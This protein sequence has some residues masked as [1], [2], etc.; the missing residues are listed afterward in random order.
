[1]PDRVR[2]AAF[3]VALAPAGALTGCSAP[4]R[5]TVR[6][7]A[8]EPTSCAAAVAAAFPNGPGTLAAYRDVERRCASLEE[9]ARRKAF[10]G[11]ILRLDCAPPD[12]LAMAAEI[13][14]LGRKIPAAPPELIVMPICRQFNA[15][16]ADYD[17]L[18]RDHATLARKPTMANLGLFVHHRALYDGCVRKYG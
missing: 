5:P 17:E 18:R 3:L 1:M 12:I 15:E 13:P 7:A 2:V 16:C 14:G 11:S 4:A 10:D 9:L 6:T 8:A